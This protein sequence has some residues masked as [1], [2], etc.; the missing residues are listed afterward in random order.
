MTTVDVDQI[1]TTIV[2]KLQYRLNEIH[3]SFVQEQLVMN[4]LQKNESLMTPELYKDR[5][6]IV[7][8]LKNTYSNIYNVCNELT[9]LTNK[10]DKLQE[11][12][13]DTRDLF[14]EDDDY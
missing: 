7:E 5:H 8:N 10:L 4:M 9:I 3:R 6:D 2:Q 11:E 14:E 13:G 12:I 1:F